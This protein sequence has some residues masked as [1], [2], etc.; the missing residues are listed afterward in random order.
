[1]TVVSKSEFEYLW[2]ISSI[3]QNND[4]DTVPMIDRTL[5]GFQYGENYI[6]PKHFIIQNDSELSIDVYGAEILKRTRESD[7]YWA[8]D[9]FLPHPMIK[10]QVLFDPRKEQEHIFELLNNKMKRD[11]NIGGIIKAPPGF[12]KSFVSIKAAANFQMKTLIVV[13]NDILSE[14]FKESIV[15][16][17]NLELDD[18]GMIQGSDVISLMNNGQYDKDICI[19]KIQSLLSQI[20]TIDAMWLKQFYSRFGLV[21]YDEC[22]V[23]GSAIGYSKTAA[24]MNTNNI[25]GLSATPFLKGINN[26]LMQNSMGELLVDVDHQNLIPDITI[27]NVFVNFTEQE[28][29]RLNFAKSDYIR[30]LATHNML[31]EDKLEYLNFIADYAIYKQSIGHQVAVLFA[32]NKLVKKVYDMIVNKGGDPG[33]IIGS[34]KKVVPKLVTYIDR[35]SYAN[36]VYGFKKYFPK[37]KFKEYSE[38]TKEEM[39]GYHLTKP[40][41]K[42][43]EKLN[44]LMKT[45]DEELITIYEYKKSD[46][47]EREL[48][49]EKDIIVSNFKLLSAGYD[50]SS[51]SSILIG[52]PLIGKIPVIQTVGRVTRIDDSKIQ[53]ITAQF[54]FSS[55]YL[56][57]FPSMAHVLANNLR[58]AFPDSKYHYDGFNFDKE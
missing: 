38:K 15:Q 12:G 17:S 23:S 27:H 10:M 43:I 40:F 21:F 49:N 53:E 1:M 41:L 35:E 6:L 14:Q 50:K 4:D 20:K 9:I 57:H 58:I 56:K 34:T 3:W 13:P 5:A 32:N 44:A 48:M 22:H 55:E 30:F 42:D 54:F 33:M 11:G 19:V 2:N 37:R 26:F 8:Q 46:K 39:L 24:I 25:V 7:L 51:L 31:L 36:Y 52:S 28:K 16:F 18:I 45:N 29:G 47:T